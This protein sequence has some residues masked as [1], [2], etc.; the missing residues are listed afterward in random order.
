MEQLSLRLGAG[1]S[2]LAEKKELI[3]N[4]DNLPKE[5][6]L[7]LLKEIEELNKKLLK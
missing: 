4:Y 7:K 6:K 3:I 1:G 5:I 2:K